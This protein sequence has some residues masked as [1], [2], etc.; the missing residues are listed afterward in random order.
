[1]ETAAMMETATALRASTVDARTMGLVAELLAVLRSR[2]TNAEDRATQPHEFRHRAGEIEI[3][4]VFR[5]VTVAGNP[6][7]L[8]PK[9]Y[10]L[11]VALARNNGAPVSKKTLLRDV[12]NQHVD[13]NSR[14][15]DQHICELRRKL[16]PDSQSPKRIMT[17]RKY[18]Y[19]LRRV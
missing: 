2:D 1:M 18:G 4:E 8:R 11:I 3:D 10:E 19:A 14:S 12:W 5:T 13:T 6:V 7:Q 16:E 9:E 17:I 15:L